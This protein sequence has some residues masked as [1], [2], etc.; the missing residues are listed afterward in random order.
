MI[1]IE[2]LSKINDLNILVIGDIIIDKYIDGSVGRISPE[3]PIP[4]LNATSSYH[5]LGG[6]ANVANNISSLGAKCTLVGKAGHD[7]NYDLLIELLENNKIDAHLIKSKYFKTIS[8]TRI[9][10]NEHQI[11]RIDEELIED[12]NE[13]EISQILEYVQGKLFDIIIVSDYNKGFINQNLITELQ[14]LDIPII[15]DPKPDNISLYKGVHTITPNK[16]EAFKAYSEND[17]E[18]VAIKLRK[19]I[20]TNVVIT[21]GKEGVMLCC[22]GN[23]VKRI[24]TTAQQVI[25]VSGAGDTFISVYSLFIALKCELQEAVEIANIACGLVVKKIG[26]ATISMGELV[27][28]VIDNERLETQKLM[29]SNQIGQL[30]GCNNDKVVFTNGCFDIIHE[31]HVRLLKEAKS[32]G[33]L[34]VVG[35]NSDSSVKKLKGNDRP[36]NST[37]SRI[38]VLS[39]ISHV[40]IIVVFDQETPEE[41]IKKIKPD[42][43]VKGGDY[44]ASNVV[45]YDFVK[46]YGGKVEI[47]DLIEGKSTTN[48]IQKLRD[49]S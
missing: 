9:I 36:I 6:A 4:V 35:I 19:E 17:I 41:L 8:K 24:P 26:T 38:N 15:V 30:V 22:S 5:R 14:N 11:V 43:L 16:F 42:I 31:G 29:S 7:A 45:G 47:I 27:K 18:V 40:D 25:D 39:S 46:S 34:L 23:N 32:L 13:S 3:A 2:L 48:L 10:S 49:E 21:M 44:I 28:T 12:T 37:E 1:K 20:K 33:D